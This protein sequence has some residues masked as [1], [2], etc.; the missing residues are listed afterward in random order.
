MSLQGEIILRMQSQ[1]VVNNSKQTEDALGRI[2]HKADETGKRVESQA[3]Q[4]R[5]SLELCTGART[6]SE[7]NDCKF[8]RVKIAELCEIYPALSI[9]TDPRLDIIRDLQ[10]SM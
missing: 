2:G 4:F 1:Q 3:A 6:I 5:E 7:V 8:L 9:C 10:P